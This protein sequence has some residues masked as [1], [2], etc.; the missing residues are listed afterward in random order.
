MKFWLDANAFVTAKNSIYALEINKTLWQWMDSQLREGKI[1]TPA[2]VYKELMA[3]KGTDLLKQWAQ[4][5][6]SIGMCIQ[7]DAKVWRAVTKVAD[8]L[9]TATIE[10]T[11]PRRTVGRYSQAQIDEFSR[12]ADHMV[13]AHAMADQGIVVT[14]ETDKKPEAQRIRIP[15]V[16]AV[17]DVECIDLRALLIAKL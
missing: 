15:D 3:Y 7:P 16:C 8:H 5:R 14:F 4:A 17:F 2:R 9:Y 1:A 6:E 13:I 12:G 11:R 10:K